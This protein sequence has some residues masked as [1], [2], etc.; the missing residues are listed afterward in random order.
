MNK[1]GWIVGALIAGGTV[2]GMRG[3]LSSP[4]PDAKLATHISEMCRI[5]KDNVESP[6]KGVRQ[7]GRFY[8]RNA[9]DMLEEFGDAIV[10]IEKISDDAKHDAR[11][12]VMRDRLHEAALGC[13]PH[14]T[15]FWQAVQEDPEAAELAQHSA[16]RLSRTFDILLGKNY[17]LRTLPQQLTGALE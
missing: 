10:M 13:E 5:A 4:A 12:R 15:H 3:C 7:L 16:E 1:K 8:A 9:G 17:D 14:W 6:E 2:Y 11:A